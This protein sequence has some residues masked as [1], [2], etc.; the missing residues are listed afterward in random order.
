MRKQLKP[1]RAALAVALALVAGSAA[2]VPGYVTSTGEGSITD[3][4]GNC[5]RT[6]DWTPD[7]AAAPAAGRPGAVHGDR[8]GEPVER[9]A[10]RVRQG[11]AAARRAPEA[12]RAGEQ[13]QGRP[14]RPRRDRRPR[15]SHRLGEIQRAA[16]A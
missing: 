8:E 1:S 2:A 5:W 14:R 3:S 6:G 4:S 15:R 10:V 12:R 13:H 16:L 7:K 11:R 9:R